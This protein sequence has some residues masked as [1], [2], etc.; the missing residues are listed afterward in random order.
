MRGKYERRKHLAAQALADGLNRHEAAKA[1]GVDQSTIFRWMQKGDFRNAIEQAKAG[2]LQRRP[3]RWPG[4]TAIG[5]L[6]LNWWRVYG[7]RI[8]DGPDEWPTWEAW[9]EAYAGV[10]EEMLANDAAR[11]EAQLQHATLRQ[12]LEKEPPKVPACEQIW[13]AMQRGEDP[14]QEQQTISDELRDN[15]PRRVLL[16]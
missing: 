3:Q 9:A 5:G 2:T 16:R 6:E 1:A 8:G 10:R 13:Q 4:R 14:E 7:P 12:Q 15:D 11:R